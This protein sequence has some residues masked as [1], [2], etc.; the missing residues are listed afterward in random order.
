M[1]LLSDR[2]RISPGVPGYIELSQQR[3]ALNQIVSDYKVLNAINCYKLVP[4]VLEALQDGWQPLG[5][6]NGYMGFSQAMVKY[7]PESVASKGPDSRC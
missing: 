3:P 2:R 1:Q 6:V 5:G 7:A 4:L